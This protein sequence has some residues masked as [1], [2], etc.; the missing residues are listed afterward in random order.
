M[1]RWGIGVMGRREKSKKKFGNGDLLVGSPIYNR[2]MFLR[3][4]DFG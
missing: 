3:I 1:G 4:E 2:G